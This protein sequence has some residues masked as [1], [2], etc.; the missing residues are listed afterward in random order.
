MMSLCAF[1]ADRIKAQDAFD[2][3][4]PPACKLSEGPFNNKL[5]KIAFDLLNLPH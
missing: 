1:L 4:N 3:W 2:Q 5:H